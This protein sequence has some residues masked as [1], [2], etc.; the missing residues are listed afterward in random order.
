[1]DK[2]EKDLRVLARALRIEK[3]PERVKKPSAE[4]LKLFV[5]A[6]RIRK[7]PERMGR[8]KVRALMKIEK[9]KLATTPSP[10]E[11]TPPTERHAEPLTEPE[12]QILPVE[13]LERSSTESEPP[14]VM[15]EVESPTESGPLPPEAPG[16]EIEPR[17]K[18]DLQADPDNFLKGA[19]IV[20]RSL[21]NS[22]VWFKSP[23]HRDIWLWVIGKA[24]YRDFKDG[25]FICHRGELYTT[26]NEIIEAMRFCPGHRNIKPSIQQVRDVLDWF[27]NQGMIEKNYVKPGKISPRSPQVS[28]RLPNYCAVKEQAIIDSKEQTIITDLYRTG[29]LRIKLI[30]YEPYQTLQNYI[31]SLKNR[32]KEQAINEE[33]EQ[34]K[35]NDENRVRTPPQQATPRKPAIIKGSDSPKKYKN[36]NNNKKP[37][38]EDSDELRLSSLFLEEI[39]KGREGLGVSPI[40]PP[41]LQNWA[42]HI[43]LL[44]RLDKITPERI[45]GVIKYCQRSYLGR[46]G[47]LLSTEKLRKHFQSLEQ[48]MASEKK[49]KGPEGPKEDPWQEAQREKQE[50]DAKAS[51]KKEAR[52]T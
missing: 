39:Q 42:R 40:K 3:D 14:E 12:P 22:E 7:D 4:D 45:E 21:F 37:F 26:Y 5:E 16:G 18:A 49:G 44:I 46:N 50:R 51:T 11:A 19:F 20:S 43:D 41:N 13:N 24:S 1:M 47:N 30:N 38:V 31:N 8:V 6:E 34:A 52:Q 32:G 17:S 27:V 9:I 2:I 25:D 33:K 29:A 48:Q 10:G 35:K 28:P 36:L 23:L 15:T